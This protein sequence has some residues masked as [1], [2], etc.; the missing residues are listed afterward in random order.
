MNT[1][2][3]VLLRHLTHSDVWDSYIWPHRRL[4]LLHLRVH[5]RVHMYV[6]IDYPKLLI[7]RNYSITSLIIQPRGI[8]DE[9]KFPLQR[10]TWTQFLTSVTWCFT[11]ELWFH[12]YFSCCPILCLFWINRGKLLSHNVS[13]GNVFSEKDV[14]KKVVWK[15]LQI[16]KTRNM[17]GNQ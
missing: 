17:M 13:K 1:L 9:F 4:A 11:T 14:M 12:S 7:I 5:T 15:I 2:T 6:T 8:C 16:R 3:F 10:R